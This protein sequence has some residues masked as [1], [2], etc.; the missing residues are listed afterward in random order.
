MRF[1]QTAQML[2]KRGQKLLY[3]RPMNKK[4]LII[5]ILLLVT[6]GCSTST[7]DAANA[8]QP[9]EQTDAEPATNTPEA[10]KEPA[11][12]ADLNLTE[13]PDCNGE[14]PHPMG[15]SIAD[16]FID[17]TDYTQVMT[18]FCNGFA[19]EDIV[20]ALETQLASGEP[21]SNLL[22]MVKNGMDWES[23]WVEIGI[24]EN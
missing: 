5:L 11:P 18:W 8:S 22:A 21:A 9:A 2:Q 3:N 13:G 17:I 19:F 1:P 16:V 7:P 6:A 20:T 14:E 10:E 23:I 24:V 15:E 12:T 4:L